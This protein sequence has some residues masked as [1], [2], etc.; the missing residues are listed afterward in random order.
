MYKRH[1]SSQDSAGNLFAWP[2]TTLATGVASRTSTTVST[3]YLLVKLV[4]EWS[5]ASIPR[6]SIF[7]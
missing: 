6:G 7:S 5:P 3:V 2:A 1:P 4:M